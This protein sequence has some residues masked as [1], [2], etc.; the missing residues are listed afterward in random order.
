MFYNKMAKITAG[1]V[2][3]VS[4]SE[5]EVLASIKG[6]S[7]YDIDTGYVSCNGKCQSAKKLTNFHFC[8]CDK[9]G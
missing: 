8:S 6:I 1:N 7:N 4:E 5:I 9:K 3:L 2:N